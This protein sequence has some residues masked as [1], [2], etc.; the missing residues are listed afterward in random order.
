MIDVAKMVINGGIV[1]ATNAVLNEIKQ[2]YPKAR[3]MDE[4]NFEDRIPNLPDGET[5]IIES[6]FS[7]SEFVKCLMGNPLNEV[8]LFVNNS[9]FM[10][11]LTTN[12][13]IQEINELSNPAP[14][15]TTPTYGP[16]GKEA[17][18]DFLVEIKLKNINSVPEV[19]YK[20]E[21]IS[22]LV[23]VDFN[24]KTEDGDLCF[25]ESELHIS[26]FKDNEKVG[27]KHSKL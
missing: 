10:E 23:D 3:T 27:Y 6:R 24:W 4:R 16:Y 2:V 1:I 17:L 18:D 9:H 15:R 22:A 26:H 20:G 19:F 8:L 14:T 21:K 12:I 7:D 25:G 11:S 13:K 5:Y